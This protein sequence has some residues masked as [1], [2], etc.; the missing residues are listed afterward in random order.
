MMLVQSQ[1]YNWKALLAR[2][3]EYAGLAALAAVFIVPFLWMLS[4][5]LKSYEQSMQFPPTLIPTPVVWENFPYVWEQYNLLGYLKNSV[6][7]VVIIMVFQILLVVPTA[8]A[9]ATK[10]FKGKKFFFSLVIFGFMVPTEVTF[11]PVY[12]L[13]SKV[14]FI[15][16]YMALTIP[17]FFSAFGTFLFAQTFRQIPRELLESAS[18]DGASEVT[19]IFRIMLPM[20]KS[21]FVSFLLFSLVAHWN[22]YFWTMVMTYT[23]DVRTIP[24][25]VANILNSGEMKNWSHIMA[26]NVIMM[27]PMLVAYCFSNKHIKTALAYGGI[28]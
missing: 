1:K 19:K 9:F 27:L 11:V 20:A 18:L 10:E 23:P 8:Y 24:C 16:T 26:A 14:G 13:F 3:I 17:F 5:S 22:D 28:K 15:N 21:T 2:L 12:L 4:T 25:A 6:L 7:V